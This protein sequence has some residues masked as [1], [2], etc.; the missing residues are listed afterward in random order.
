MRS[1]ID[2]DLHIKIPLAVMLPRV[3]KPNRKVIINLNNYRNWQFHLNNQVKQMYKEL[4]RNDLEGIVLPG[5]VKL[6]FILHQGTKR[7]V[8]RS[9]VLSIHEKF[10]CDALTA[11]GCIKDDNDNFI[12]KTVY[13]SGEVSKEDPH[14]EVIIRPASSL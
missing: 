1:I 14:V 3:T 9:N 5:K 11:Y 6:Y 13:T 10:F 12:E 8:D 2:G 7:R 4:L